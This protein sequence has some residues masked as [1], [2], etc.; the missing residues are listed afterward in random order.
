ME[1]PCLANANSFFPTQE[2]RALTHVR[3]VL[4]NRPITRSITRLLSE[5][6]TEKRDCMCCSA[7]KDDAPVGSVCRS[8]A[9]N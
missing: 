1:M 7:G 6:Y 3:T 9:N 2:A 4:S 5:G 8:D